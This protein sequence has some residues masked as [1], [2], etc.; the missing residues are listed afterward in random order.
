MPA[1]K[2]K[3]T[4]ILNKDE[5]IQKVREVID[6]D[7][8]Y[9]ILRRDPTVK[10]ENRISH[11]L[12]HLQKYIDDTL[13]DHLTPTP[14][15]HS[16]TVYQRSTKMAYPC[17]RLAKELAWI[18]SPFAGHN[19]YTVKNSTTFAEMLYMRDKDNTPGPHGIF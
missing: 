12:K 18:L 9:R 5:Y 10:T 15:L 8:K 6:D 16:C 7:S 2:G 13:L 17:Y 14:T 19:G 3:A 1:D 11:A 4:V